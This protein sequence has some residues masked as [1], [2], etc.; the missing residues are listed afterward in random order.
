MSDGC[1]VGREGVGK[2]EKAKQSPH[3]WKGW[4]TSFPIRF[5]AAAWP[6]SRHGSLAAW[7]ADP[8]R[9]GREWAIQPTPAGATKRLP[10]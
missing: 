6:G 9:G 3:Q 1:R 7:Q 5:L 4:R 2:R 10:T 8:F